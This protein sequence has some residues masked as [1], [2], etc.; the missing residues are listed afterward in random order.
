MIQ[1]LTYELSI[2]AKSVQHKNLSAASAHVGLSQPQLSRVIAK[3]ENELK[4]VL[5]D[6][7]ARRKSGWTPKAQ[8]LALTFSKGISRIEAE[9]YAL[10]EEREITELHIG[11]LEGLS[12]ISTQ[13]VKQCFEKLGI[14]TIFHDVLDFAE[15]DSQFLGGN[16]DLIFTVRPPS[17]QKFNHIVEIGFQQNE[18]VETNENFLVFSPFE[19]TAFD[20]K[21]K[22]IEQNV[23]VCNSLSLRE[24]W[25][26]ENG[27]VGSLPVD[28]KK[29]KGKGAFTIYLIGSD[30]ISPKLWDQIK[31]LT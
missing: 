6:R 5:L 17:K 26:H 16:L 10:A 18:L 11:S 14:K 20:K 7:T 30:L 15:M 2:L 28:A 21:Q 22:R 12:N 25:L 9:V 8:E 13:F 24:H 23:L 3:I 31:E 29:G 19:Y 27:G 1:S 4:I